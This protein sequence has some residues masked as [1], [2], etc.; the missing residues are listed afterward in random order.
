VV[1]VVVL[2]ATVLENVPKKSGLNCQEAFGPICTV[3]K[4]SD[5]KQVVKEVNDSDFG[6]QTGVFTQNIHKAFYAFNNLHVG[7]VLINDIPSARVDSQPVN[8]GGV[9]GVDFC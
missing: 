7:G 9:A 8:F 3:T 1:Y 2:D 5:F 6:L 4:F